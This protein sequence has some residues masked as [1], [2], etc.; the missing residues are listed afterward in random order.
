MIGRLLSFEELE[1]CA[2]GTAET[3]LPWYGVTAGGVLGGAAGGA[4]TKKLGPTGRLAGTLVGALAGTSGGLHGGE[5]VGR[6]L[7]DKEIKR[8]TA[9]AKKQES[10]AKKVLKVM[11]TYG[12][13]FLGGGLVG[14]GLGYGGSALYRAAT[15]K[16]VSAKQ[17]AGAGALISGGLGVAYPML[18]R[19]EKRELDRAGQSTS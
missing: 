15:G 1:K 7:D 6:L 9:E 12:A 4:L 11:G 14:G 2:A 16:S 13:G 10:R 18:R 5:A 8:K 17:L 19:I 3:Y